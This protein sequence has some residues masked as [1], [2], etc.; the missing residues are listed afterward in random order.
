MDKTVFGERV[1]AIRKKK[2]MTQSQLAEA[3]GKKETTIRKYENGSI[4][5]PW[6]VIEAIAQVLD[7]SPYDLTIDVEQLKSD[8]KFFD[9]IQ[10]VFGE[11]AVLLLRNFD[12]LNSIGKQKACDYVS[13]LIDNPKFK[14]VDHD[15][16]AAS[17][18]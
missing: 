10:Q 3:I 18:D 13:D 9:D 8:A 7:V 11:D 6:N 5:A 17:N 16:V 14:I 2:R 1:K 12:S 4:E 15:D